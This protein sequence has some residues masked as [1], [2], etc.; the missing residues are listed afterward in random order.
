MEAAGGLQVRPVSSRRDWRAFH[1]VR[2]QV[3][4]RDPSAVMPLDRQEREKLDPAVHPFYEHA[5][6]EVFVCW[7]G[8]RPVGRVAAIVDHLHRQVHQDDVG[9][10]GFFE[11]PNRPDVARTLLE[12]A[13]QW[14]EPFGCRTLRGPVSPSLKGE[15]GVQV[16][17]HET[18][19]FIMMAYT[20]KYYDDLLRGLG[21]EVVKSFYAYRC[22]FD[23]LARSQTKYA[24]VSEVCRKIAERFPELEPGTLDPRDV[25]GELRRMNALANDVRQDVWGFVPLTAAELD[26]MVRQVRR[27]LDPDLFAFVRREGELVGYLTMLPDVNWALQRSV[28][29]W[30]WLRIPQLLFWL[31]RTRRAR[32]FAVGAHEKY[33]HGGIAVLLMKKLFDQSASRYQEFEISWI[34]EDNAR[35]FRSL[36]RMLPVTLYK[37]YCLYDRSMEPFYSCDGERGDVA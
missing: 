5:E 12:T 23:E 27:V 16:S 3:Y 29:R 31:R 35:S 19:P 4:R 26:Y 32:V 28:G 15:F 10:F 11:A 25:D 6:R 36:Q 34:V 30:D 13:R 33:R 24:E 14:L 22:G 37:T 20:P 7:E 8:R 17:G 2:R 1:Q 21:F 18:P 9:F